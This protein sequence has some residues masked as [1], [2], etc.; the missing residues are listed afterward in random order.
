MRL[1]ETMPDNGWIGTPHGGVKMPE[2]L[3]MP[4]PT[5]RFGQT[6]ARLKSLSLG[7]LMEEWLRFMAGVAEAQHIAASAM[8]Q[9]KLDQVTVQRAMAEGLPP[10]A[11]AYHRRDPIWR[12]GLRMLLDSGDTETTPALARAAIRRVRAFDAP[13]VEALADGF[14]CGSVASTELGHAFYV[15]AALQVY[16]TRLAAGLPEVCLHLLSER[17]LCPCCGS[18]P[19][20]GVVSE[21]G[22]VAGT[23]YLHCSLCGTAWNH[24]RAVCITCHQSRSLVLRSIG[25][26]R[27]AVQAETCD[28]CRTYAKMLYRTRRAELDPFADDLATVDLDVAAAEAGWSRHA[29][30]PLLLI[31]SGDEHCRSKD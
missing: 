2:A 18:T 31:G 12:D 9:P 26:E 29:P 4:D 13:R 7:H 23:R 21:A 14:L 24:V 27:D 28:E 3:I 30:N 1:E 11:A 25:G 22:N 10:L 8:G 17:G 19:V 20:A 5:K 16:F 15:A 6:A